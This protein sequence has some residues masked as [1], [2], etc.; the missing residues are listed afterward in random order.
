MVRVHG[1]KMRRHIFF[2]FHRTRSFS[3]FF[4]NYPDAPSSHPRRMD[5]LPHRFVEYGVSKESMAY[6]S[7]ALVVLGI[8][9]PL[10]ISRL[11]NGPRPLSVFL[12]GVPLR[13]VSGV[14]FAGALRVTAVLYTTLKQDAASMGTPTASLLPPNW[15][16]VMFLGAT[17]FN[18]IASNLMFV[19]QMS[20]FNK[21]SDPVIG[22][23]YMTLLNTLANLGSKWPQSLSLALL[24][25]LTTREC[26]SGTT[27]LEKRGGAS[28]QSS[29]RL[30]SAI[31]LSSF[32][33]R[34]SEGKASCIASGGTCAILRD[35][36]DVQLV[37]CTALGLIWFALLWKKTFELQKLPKSSWAL[38]SLRRD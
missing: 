25:V 20:F 36:Y 29:R 30:D 1:K 37:I 15:F 21:V 10:S 4:P 3:F 2:L 35:G 6:F 33:C 18:N 14:A 19:S 31:E 8:I 28:L 26:Q 16:W 7:P 23:T 24:D 13:L 5:I 12:L 34:S 32:S 27:E 38:S 9:V 22:G 17:A 11:T